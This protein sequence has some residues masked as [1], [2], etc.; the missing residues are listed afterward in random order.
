M[1]KALSA[2]KF[3]ISNSFHI[4]PTTRSPNS[5]VQLNKVTFPLNKHYS[6]I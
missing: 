4:I 6:E 3:Y 5:F 1:T 2:L